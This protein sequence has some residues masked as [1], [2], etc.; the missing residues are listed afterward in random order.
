MSVALEKSKDDF[1]LSVRIALLRRGQTLTELASML[2]YARNTVSLAVNHGL[3]KEV[4]R[5]IME[6]LG[7]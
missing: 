3:F 6:E 2:G 5:R 4:R 1:A 7:L